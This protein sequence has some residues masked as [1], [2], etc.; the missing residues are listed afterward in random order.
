MHI[1]TTH[2]SEFP[3]APIRMTLNDL[4]CPIHLKMRL[5]DVR[6]L[7]VL[8]STICI[9][10]AREGRGSGLEGLAPPPVHVGS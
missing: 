9:G 1:M 7:R 8:D 6:W 3:S 5:V 10:V 2:H 4:E